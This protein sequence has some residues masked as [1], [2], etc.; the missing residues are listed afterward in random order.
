MDMNNIESTSG[1]IYSTAGLHRSKDA[2][3]GAFCPYH[4]SNT[5][6]STD[7]PQGA[8]LFASYGE[9]WIPSIPGAQI[10]LEPQLQAAEEF[11]RGEYWPWIQAREGKLSDDLKEKLWKLTSKEFPLYS[12]TFTVLPQVSW[13]QVETMLKG[14]ASDSSL[15][16]VKHFLRKQSVR[17]IDWL[18]TYGYCQDHLRPG[19]STVKQA[20]WGAFANRDL[21]AG[22]IVGYSPL[23]HMGVH[24]RDLYWITYPPEADPVEHKERRRYD[25]ILNY[26]FGHKNSTVLLTPY[27]GM[28][29]YINHKSTS[30]DGA[31]VKIRWPS[32][33]LV[34]HKPWWLKLSPDRLRDTTEKIG[35]SFEYVATRNIKEGE[36]VFMDYGDE[37]EAAWNEHVAKWYPPPDAMSYVHRSDWPE[38]YVRTVDEEAYP[39][40]LVTVCIESFT[41]SVDPSDG[42][43]TNVWA[44]LMSDTPHRVYCRALE[45]VSKP[46]DEDDE[47]EEEDEEG[48]DETETYV[49]KVEL[50]L[51]V[52]SKPTK[53]VVEGVPPNGI[54]LVD[55]AYSQDWH[56]PNAFRHEIMIPDDVMPEAW[57]NGP[58]PPPPSEQDSDPQFPVGDEDDDSD[59]DYDDEE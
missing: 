2:G 1:S 48:N 40:N 34:A 10:T 25:L 41:S 16:V 21:P 58:P 19:I 43:V 13:D 53:L 12:K 46:K 27:G 45:R 23:I 39:D 59:D 57:R 36:E 42:T 52:D 44:P 47:D 4:K 54:F 30:K 56:I 14:H 7:I 55:R 11:L 37:W 29:N 49:Y 22:T 15:N 51:K 33:E 20:G 6:A 17:T 18:D 26:S 50:D 38:K 32:E 3:A 5:T 8:E 24:G 31:N 35:L 9:Y 28:V